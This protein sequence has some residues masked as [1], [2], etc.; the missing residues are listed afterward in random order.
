MEGQTHGKCITFKSIEL[1][2]IDAHVLKV[3]V[4]SAK[5]PQVAK[6]ETVWM[7]FP[8]C[9]EFYSAAIERLASVANADQSEQLVTELLLLWVPNSF[10]KPMFCTKFEFSALFLLSWT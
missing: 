2:S 8:R 4:P 10:W 7:G 9:C 1:E 6:E 3:G 5:V